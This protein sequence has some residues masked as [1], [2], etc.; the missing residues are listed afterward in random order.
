MALAGTEVN[1][2]RVNEGY[3]FLSL[4]RHGFARF[5]KVPSCRLCVI[6]SQGRN[7]SIRQDK[8]GHILPENALE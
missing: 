1:V 8:I 5:A 4:F 2:R 7:G 3:W 6:R